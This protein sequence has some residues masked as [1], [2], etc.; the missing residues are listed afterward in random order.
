MLFGP[1]HLGSFDIPSFDNSAMDGYAI[2]GTGQT[3]EIVGEISA[4]DIAAKA[5]QPGQ[6]MRIFT[7][8]KVPAN[9]TA[10]VMQEKTAVEGTT[11]H[12]QEKLR[13]G[14]NIRRKGVELKTG[15]PV[16]NRVNC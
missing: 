11:L 16:L 15:Q 14:Q 13:P 4:G 12:V 3:F 8:G 9:A 6:A 1:S 7:G 2:C 10:V 5:I